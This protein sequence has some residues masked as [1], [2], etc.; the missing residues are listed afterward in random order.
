MATLTVTQPVGEGISLKFVHAPNGGADAVS[1][2]VYL[3]TTS[4]DNQEFIYKDFVYTNNEAIVVLSDADLNRV[5]TEA[6]H[7]TR[8]HTAEVTMSATAYNGATTI[9]QDT[10]TGLATAKTLVY[11]SVPTAPL[12]TSLQGQDGYISFNFTTTSATSPA[13]ILQNGNVLCDI[14]VNSVTYGIQTF[15]VEAITQ[16]TNGSTHTISARTEDGTL[17]NATN[18]EAAIRVANVNGKSLFSETQSIVPSNIPNSLTIPVAETYYTSGITLDQTESGIAAVFGAKWLDSDADKGTSVIVRFGVVDGNNE[19]NADTNVQQGTVTLNAANFTTEATS[20]P[21]CNV[22]NAWFTSAQNGSDV[23]QLQIVARIEQTTDGVVNYSNLT[24]PL[25]VYKITL[26]TLSAITIVAVTSTGTQGFNTVSGGTLVDD[27]NVAGTMTA[28]YNGI[29][30]GIPITT[31][32]NS[33]TLMDG[34]FILDYA[35]IDAGSNGILTFTLQLPDA[36]GTQ[37]SGIVLYKA[38]STQALHAFKDPESP[39]PSITGGAVTVAP[40]IEVT[41][42]GSNFGYTLDSYDI[43]VFDQLVT[44]YKP[45]IATADG[46]SRQ[47]DS[48]GTS[49][50]VA[51]YKVSYTKNLSGIP[52][53]YD[54]KYTTPTI[55]GTSSGSALYFINPVI[56][57]VT[58]AGPDMLI[59]GNT[60]G[61]TF[62]SGAIT[63]LGFTAGNSDDDFDISTQTANMPPTGTGNLAAYAFTVIVTHA[64]GT[65][66]LNRNNAATGGQFDGFGFVNASNANSALSILNV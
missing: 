3:A 15:T 6:L 19:F 39:I 38:T 43:V 46:S 17:V 53:D 64:Q 63:S 47:A 57:S 54:G 49:Y 55:T 33:T 18:Y 21:N 36:N 30:I 8:D 16:S 14:I 62:T 41:T 61:A 66:V 60:G 2:T 56:S 4:I 34:N 32:N 44:T 51:D 7:S 40:T 13:L 28:K 12:V 24:T 48:T 59:T 29:T 35:T 10:I 45:Y 26:P 31:T 9:T 58:I 22:R 1:G 23:T 42:E 50:I 5:Y 27:R 37:Q 11:Q 52:S 20:I 25:T 65:L